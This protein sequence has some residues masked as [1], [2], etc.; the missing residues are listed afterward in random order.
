MNYEEILSYLYKRTPAFHKIG[1]NAYNA[2]L[3]RS[4]S[5]DYN[6]GSPHNRYKSIHVAGTNGKGAVSHLLAA[7]LQASGYK[8][9]LYTSPHLLNFCERIRVNGL[10]ITKQYVID[11]VVK[12][13]K[14]IENEK[15]SFFELRTAMA[16]DYFR[17][18]KVNYAI[19]ET[20][21]GGRLDSTNII[22]PILSIITSISM[23]HTNILGDTLEK[24][25]NEKAGIIKSGIPVIIGEMYNDELKKIFQNKGNELLSPVIFASYKNTL[26]DAE[27]QLN[28]SWIFE[29]I[30]YGRFAGELR[31]LSQMINT[32]T[33]LSA[34]HFLSHSGTQIRIQAI[35]KAFKQVTQMTGFAGRW[36]ELQSKPKVICDIG[37]NVGAWENNQRQLFF[38]S[39]QH[40]K[41]HIVFGMSNDKDIDGVLSL[42]PDNATYYF[43]NASNERALTAKELAQKGKINGLNGNIFSNVKEAVLN[44]LSNASE[45]DFIFIGGSTFVVAEALT[46]FPQ[47]ILK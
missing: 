29:S 31:G 32:Q 35:R 26:T 14:F 25:A 10:P 46:L 21:L 41:T 1:S 2:G 44:A 38:E 18:K 11:F 23:E 43:T 39:K 40:N 12:N 17:H 45:N 27:M 4:L 13:I 33:V 47:T 6:L 7:V 5:L 36:H 9:G 30:N 24:I 34:L 8:V 20:G 37:H 16:F 15:L 28:G 42:L 22:T 19:I 3:E